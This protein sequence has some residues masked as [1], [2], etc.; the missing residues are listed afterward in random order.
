[1]PGSLTGAGLGEYLSRAL[2]HRAAL[3]EPKDLAWPIAS[4]ARDDGD[5]RNMTGMVL[6]FL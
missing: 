3:A 1:M 5:G 4:Y 6:I 2:S